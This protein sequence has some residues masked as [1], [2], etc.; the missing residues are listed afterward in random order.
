M[1]RYPFLISVPHG[2]TAVP[3]AVAALVALSSDEIQY[4]SDPSTRLV[5]SFRDRVAWYRDTDISRMIVDLNR[6]PYHLPPK[7]PDGVVKVRTVHGTP[8]FRGG[9]VPEIT[10][11]HQLLMAHYFPYHADLDRL[12]EPAKI[13]LALDCHSMLPEGPPTHRDA[14]RQRPMV[15]LGNNGDAEGK[16]RPGTLSTCPAGWIT[17][18]AGAFREELGPGADVAINNPFSGG[19]ITNAHYWHRGIPWIQVEVSRALY[20]TSSADPVTASPDADLTRETGV[21][22]WNALSRFW[23]ELG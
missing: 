9:I 22:V 7:H 6:P 5:Y 10:L 19:F 4:Y 16:R 23:D 2:G 8:V 1:G 20:E 13:A 18:L 17:A 3:E 14:G 12:L 21:L 15:C 11:I